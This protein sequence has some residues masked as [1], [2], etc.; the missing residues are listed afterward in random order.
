MFR[1]NVLRIACCLLLVIFTCLMIFVRTEGFPQ[2]GIVD[3]LAGVASGL[4]ISA[5]A[6]KLIGRLGMAE[7]MVSYLPESLPTNEQLFAR[8][9]LFSGALVSA[10]ICASAAW[11][12]YHFVSAS[13]FLVRNIPISATLVGFFAFWGFIAERFARYYD[14]L[15]E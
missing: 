12:F 15:P 6:V 10:A 8:Y 7:M 3:V 1:S 11:G 5:L 13:E 9:K 14:S 4:V 2:P